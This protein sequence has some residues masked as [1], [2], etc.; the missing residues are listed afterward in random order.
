MFFAVRMTTREDGVTFLPLNLLDYMF[1]GLAAVAERAVVLTARHGHLPERVRNQDR[2]RQEQE[3]D[4]PCRMDIPCQNSC[5]Y[6][7]LAHYLRLV[8]R[9]RGLA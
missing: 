2:R 1:R 6:L 9:R 3:R 8:L 4:R 7:L 5:Y